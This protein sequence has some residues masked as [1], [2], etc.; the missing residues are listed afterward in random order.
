M[1]KKSIKLP[2]FTN[3]FYSSTIG[4]W[5][6]CQHKLG[7]APS[8]FYIM[9]QWKNFKKKDDLKHSPDIKEFLH[10]IN[11]YFNLKEDWNVPVVIVY[12]DTT[13][14]LLFTLYDGE[15]KTLIPTTPVLPLATLVYPK[16]VWNLNQEEVHGYTYFDWKGNKHVEGEVQNV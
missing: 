12:S 2:K 9:K 14:N 5:I 3:D 6:V 10:Q 13:Q 8:M 16:K 7:N 4:S 11:V 15:T 1:G